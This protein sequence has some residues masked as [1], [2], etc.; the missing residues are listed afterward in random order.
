MRPPLPGN[1]LSAA[2]NPFEVGK[3]AIF[4]SPIAQVM[5]RPTGRSSA[6]AT[7]MN[8]DM[9]VYA[10]PERSEGEASPV[11]QRDGM[12]HALRPNLRRRRATGDPS[13]SLR[14]GSG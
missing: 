7:S 6:L 1:V 3:T 14:S 5:A 13:P 2:K 4:R 10:A 9:E 11:A 8:S 12:V